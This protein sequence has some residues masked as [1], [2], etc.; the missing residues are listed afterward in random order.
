MRNLTFV[1]QIALFFLCTFGLCNLFAQSNQYVIYGIITDAATKEPLIFVSVSAPANNTGTRT[2]ENGYYSLPLSTPVKEIRVNYV[3]Y[4][5]QVIK[6]VYKERRAEINIALEQE[7]QV[8]KEVVVKPKKYRNK[9]NPA[10]ELIR[11]VVDHRD[12]NRIEGF[13]TYREEQYEKIMMGVSHL[14]EKTKNR[15]VLRSWKFALENADTN[16]LKGTGVIPAYLQETI[17][18]FYTRNN[19]DKQLKKIKATQ[20]VK[21]PLLDEDGL[22]RY[23]RY[24]YQDVDIYDNYVVL[25]T[26]HFLSPIANNAPLFYRYY[27][28]DTFEQ[29]GSKIVRLQ[30]FPRNKT[31]ML[32]QGEIFV[33]LDSTYPVTRIVFSVNPN[34]NLNWVRSL[35]VEQDFQKIMPSGKW[36]VR[37]EFLG[38]D[39]GV[40]KKW[41][42]I[43]GE[44]YISHKDPRIDEALPDSLFVQSAA[45]PDSL[46]KDTKYWEDNRHAGLSKVEAA[47]Y[48]NIDSLQKTRLFA[49]T[50]RTALLLI[51]GYWKPGY[52]L[53]VGPI[54]GLYSFNPVEG[55]RVR[56]GGRTNPEFSKRVNLEGYA[57]YGF[58]DQRWKYGIGTNISLSKS[59]AY[60]KFPYNMLRISYYEDLIQPGVIPWGTF[61][62]TNVGTS[63]NRGVNDRFFFQKR[64]NTQYEK[65]YLNHFSFMAGFERK[66]MTPLGSL[67][68]IP[69][70]VNGLAEGAPVVTAKP[71]FQIRY[72]PGEEFYQSKTGWRQRIR[73]NFIG[74]LRYSRGLKGFMGGQYQFH[75]VYASAYKFSN[76]PPIGYN[77]L[78][79]E[80][81]G[82]FGKV[83]YP[84]MTVHRANQGYGYAFMRYN[85]MNFMEFVSDRYVAV[86]MEHSFYGFFTNKIPL[87]RKLKLRE[88]ATVKVLYGQV[89]EQNHPDKSGGLYELPKYPDGTPLTYTLEKKPYIEA[90]VGIGNIFKVL[91]VEFVRR[92]TYTD[93]PG[94]NKSGV[95]FAAQMQF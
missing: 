27:P 14:S 28:A 38:L 29:S 56:F 11:L 41:A 53:E 68:F 48:H 33:A 36:V 91:R 6:V 86:N 71:F 1:A 47:T 65:E 15:R 88:L 61:V 25:M 24:I 82:L 77:Y 63:I 90:S 9:D 45:P 60:N 44:R 84:L 30:F 39:F 13:N 23:M 21:F 40:T 93:H 74:V 75:E 78:F 3:G 70:E 18:D 54:G 10:V 5:A 67:K 31:D 8:L 17:Q 4:K 89:S 20:K 87:I 35:Q 2:D 7:A 59:R 12:Q 55:D 79:M 95:R 26:D 76:L 85:L 80:A 58:R 51:A 19:P 83:P 49:R 57:A 66:A 42:G 92:M 62:R 64:F 52:G 22:E 94:I 50:A 32:L 46:K 73:F 16:K 43:Y 72:A 69:T 37:D 34:I 81:G